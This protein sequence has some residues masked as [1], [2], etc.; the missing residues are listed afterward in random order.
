M[1]NPLN[2]LSAVYQNSIA[3]GDCGCDD[4]KKGKMKVKPEMLPQGDTPM[5]GD[6][7]RPGK[8]KKA[9]VEPMSYEGYEPGDVDK[10]VG[11]VTPIP[12]KEQDAARERILAKAKKKRE[13]K[14]EEIQEALP[15]IIP[16]AGAVLAKSAAV[17]GKAL[18][19]TGKVAA[20]GAAAGARQ[21]A[22]DRVKRMV[23]GNNN[24]QQQ[25][26][27]Q[28]QQ[29]ENTYSNWREEWE[30]LD[31]YNVSNYGTGDSEK[32]LGKTFAKT[33]KKAGEK[34]TEKNVRNTIKINPPQGMGECF[35]ELGGVIHEV[36]EIVEKIDIEKAD[37]GEVVKDFRKS[38]APQFKGKSKEKKQEMAVAAKLATEETEDEKKKR[39]LLQQKTKDHD[40]KQ[41]GKIAEA[42]MKNAPSIKD[43]KTP[44]ETFVKRYP[45]LGYAPTVKKDMKEGALSGVLSTIR[46]KNGMKDITS[47]GKDKLQD[48][49]DKSMCENK[50]LEFMKNKYK[51]V[52]IDT[53]APKKQPSPEQRKADA[54]RRA[55]NYADNNKNY[56]PYKPRAGESD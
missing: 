3:E 36:Y 18:A 20:K 9:Y 40:D 13:M 37:M 4:K 41:S 2:E 24:Q 39:E 17:A 23:A 45:G 26:Q 10:K 46:A 52:L 34:I 7:A 12:K 6:G 44:T 15:A 19:A 27:Q 11:A 22:K 8:N 50:A 5:G 54:Q 35:A 28:Q 42:D 16:A 32:N 49:K 1:N 25:Q 53:K 48:K 43:A 47:K 14:E 51:D 33:D 31:E 56:N 30:F 29:Y 38:K 55:K 21:G